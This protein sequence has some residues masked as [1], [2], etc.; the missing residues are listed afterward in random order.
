[1]SDKTAIERILDQFFQAIE[2]C[3][4]SRLPLGDQVSYSGTMLPE[5]AEGSDAVRK[6]LSGTAPFIKSMRVEDTVIGTSAAAVLVRY[7]GI[8][9][10][11][12]EGC[13]FMDFENGQIA[14]IRTVFDSRPLL[15]GGPDN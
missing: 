7:E 2:N 4:M 10:V 3:D 14:R 6:Y 1:M 5:A 13:Y 8:N 15:R 9:G 11:H 12:F